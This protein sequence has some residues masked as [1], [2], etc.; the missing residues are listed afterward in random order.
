MRSITKIII[1]IA[2]LLV[3]FGLPVLLEQAINQLN[4]SPRSYFRLLKIA[5][6][7]ADLACSEEILTEHLA[8]SLQYR[9]K[10]N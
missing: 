8:E 10:N 9:L 7:I 1:V 5:R 6:T 3:T 2:I 4:L